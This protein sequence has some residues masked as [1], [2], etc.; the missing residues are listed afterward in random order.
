MRLHVITVDLNDP[1]VVVAPAL[2]SRGPGHD[3]NFAGFISRLH[4]AAAINGTFFS[5]RNLLPIGDIVTGRKLAYFGGMGTA[6][7]F[8]NDGVDLIRLP[9]G[10]RVDW[11]E[12]QSA[13]AA[14]PLLVWNGFAKPMPGGE[15]F[16]D[17]HVFA[18]A[19]PRTAMGVTR[20]NKLLLVTTIAGTS[21]GRLAQALRALGAVYAVNL[22]G[23]SSCAMWHQG[24]TI[25]SAGR[26]LTNVLCVYLQPDPAKPHTLRAPRGTGLAPRPQ[27]L[28]SHRLPRRLDQAVDRVPPRLGGGADR[29]PQQ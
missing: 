13:L 7:A 26:R 14:G 21:L 12:Y 25:K 8:A 18:K 5:K 9:R 11:W 15:G 1:R 2:A 4:P 16:G 3:E 19:A 23:G 24:R 20:S 29:A 22:D 10:R 27:A 6:L 17:P 28:P